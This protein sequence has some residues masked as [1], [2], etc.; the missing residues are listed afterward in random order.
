MVYVG[1]AA[2]GNAPTDQVSLRSNRLLRRTR[3]RKP[4][5]TKTGDRGPE[6]LVSKLAEPDSRGPY[7]QGLPANPRAFSKL[8]GINIFLKERREETE[9]QNFHFRSLVFQQSQFWPNLRGVEPT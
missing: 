3:R 9:A 8:P 4:G 7:L 6:S 5:L 2:A 1:P